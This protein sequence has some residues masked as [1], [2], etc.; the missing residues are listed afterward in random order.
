MMR[1]AFLLASV[2]AALLLGGCMPWREAQTNVENSKNLRVGMTKV[3][4]LRIMGEPLQDETF[5][6]PDLW[7]YYIETVW[8]DGLV[9]EE[10]C[11]PLVFKDG[12]LIGWGRV[13]LTKYR[14]RS[15][16]NAP[17]LI[18]PGSKPA[19]ALKAAVKKAPP[20]KKPAPAKAAPAKAAPAKKPAPAKPAPAKAAPAKKPAPAEEKAADEKK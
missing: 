6:R 2:A 18:P 5:C 15:K 16:D 12:I 7:Y 1:Q 10:E 17:N 13:F 8:A 20:A 11:M 3:E 19:E 14:L 4:V 9:A